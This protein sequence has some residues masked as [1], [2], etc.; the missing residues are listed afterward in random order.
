MTDNET[1]KLARIDVPDALLEALKKY[2]PRWIQG[3]R[4]K[5]ARATWAIEELLALLDG[6]IVRVRE[7]ANKDSE[8]AP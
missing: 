7:D 3:K 2:A 8:E 5:S 4:D 6:G 1:I